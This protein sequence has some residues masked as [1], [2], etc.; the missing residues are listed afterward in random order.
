MDEF[1]QLAG[2]AAGSAAPGTLASHTAPGN[3][4]SPHCTP[5]TLALHTVPVSGLHL[6]FFSLS[7]SNLLLLPADY[8]LKYDA[9]F[10]AWGSDLAA[11][12]NTRKLV[13]DPLPTLQHTIH[14]P[15]LWWGS[16]GAVTPMHYDNFANF[17][18]QVRR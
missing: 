15:Y 14:E 1:V 7:L 13:P 10:S 9:H 5:N 18:V 2:I 16:A 3:A 8:K 12:A 6:F 4:R 11:D 17:Y